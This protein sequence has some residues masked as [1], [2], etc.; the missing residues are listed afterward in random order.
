MSGRMEEHK[1][2]AKRSPS[3]CHIPGKLHSWPYKHPRRLFVWDYRKSVYFVLTV[4]QAPHNG[5][6]RCMLLVS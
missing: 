1:V 4:G 2:L 3:G 6:K 5:A